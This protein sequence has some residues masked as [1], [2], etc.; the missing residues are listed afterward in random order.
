MGVEAS[1]VVEA[2]GEGV[3]NVAPGDRVTYTGFVN[4]LGRVQHR[5]DHPGGASDQAAG[6]DL[7]RDRGG[8]DDARAHVGVPDA[9]HL[10]A[11]A[12]AT[13][14]CCTPRRAASG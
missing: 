12:R 9:A 6:G 8:D 7:L 14:S 3:T 5:A 1:G 11:C 4:T 13:R 2:V 10:A